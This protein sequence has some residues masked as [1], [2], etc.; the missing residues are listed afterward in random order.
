MSMGRRKR[1]RQP[2]MWVTTTQLP[3][4]ASHPFYRRLNEALRE[5]GFDDL[6]EGQ[7]AGF[8][9]ETMGRTCS[10]SARPGP[11]RVSRPHLSRC[12]AHCAVS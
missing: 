4:E 7:C 11:S 10:V 2:A 12:L 8:Y 1:D 6:V 9:A 5:R 3:T